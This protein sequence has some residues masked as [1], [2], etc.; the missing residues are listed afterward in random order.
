MDIIFW[1]LFSTGVAVALCLGIYRWANADIS[2]TFLA[3][4]F[5]FAVVDLIGWVIW[6][7][8]RAFA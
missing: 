4:A 6:H 1:S 2:A 8:W 3:L 7:A 5:A